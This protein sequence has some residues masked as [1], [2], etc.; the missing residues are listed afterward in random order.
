[1][2]FSTAIISVLNIP[3]I[4]SGNAL[5]IYASSENPAVGTYLTGGVGRY[6]AADSFAN[7]FLVNVPVILLASV[8]LDTTWERALCRCVMLVVLIG[9]FVS[10]VRAAWLSL[11]LLLV[12]WM[13]TQRRWKLIAISAMCLIVISTS[14]VFSNPLR[15]AYQKIAFEVDNIK[16]Y[17][18]P[19]QA[20][21]RRPWIWKAYGGYYINSSILV[22]I[23]GSN[24]YLRLDLGHD[25]HND[26]LH[27][28][29]RMGV[30][31]LCITI[32]L[33][34]KTG[35]SLFKT[36]RGVGEMYDRELALT[37]LLAL[38]G[39]MIPSLTRTG[40]MNPN[41]EWQFWSFA[42]LTLAAVNVP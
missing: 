12:I 28:L 29:L 3:A 32:Y 36:W 40:L 15:E 33:Y 26:F 34:L 6:Y 37:A 31:G 5:Q 24:E 11:S 13:V 4:Y 38:L 23:I 42:M 41:Y 27:M 39:M 1:M 25:P 35:V 30:I 7:A 2:L 8:V 20:F 22:Q 16:N 21:G 9:V 17:E 19:D 14:Q 18:L 10:C